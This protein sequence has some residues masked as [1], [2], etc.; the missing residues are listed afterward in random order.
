MKYQGAVII[1]GLC[2]ALLSYFKKLIAPGISIGFLSFS[3]I[4]IAAVF[5]LAVIYFRRD[6]KNLFVFRRDVPEFVLLG[7]L[8]AA[9]LYVYFLA[10]DYA[11]LNNV[12][13]LGFLAPLFALMYNRVFFKIGF[14][15]NEIRGMALAAVGA[16]FV[17]LDGLTASP[18]VLY[19]SMLAVLFAAIA[20][21]RDVLV[22]REEQKYPLID[23]LFWPF[24]FAAIFLSVFSVYEGVFVSLNSTELILLA[25]I[26]IL[27]G[28][29]FY[30]YD[31]SLEFLSPAIASSL[32][33]ISLLF[34]ALVLGVVFLGEPL[35]VFAMIGTVVLAASIFVIHPPDSMRVHYS[36]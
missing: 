11:P 3:R 21:L 8:Y 22:K 26:G 17:L 24:V 5:L 7:F 29:G 6:F 1:A 32:T 27:T 4:A 13:L 33:H 14:Q 18:G 9:A 15:T 20:G 31:F 16:G 19:G 10:L 28:I 36:H 25:A 35:T 23:V 12:V 2:Y 34:F 30:F